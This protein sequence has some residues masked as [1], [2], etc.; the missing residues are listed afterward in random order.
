MKR[1]FLFAT[2]AILIPQ[3][4]GVATATELPAYEVTG[5][6]ITSVQASVVGSAHAQEISPQPTLTLGGMP[7]S[8]H[9]VAVLT[10]RKHIVGEL[11]T[12]P[13]TEGRAR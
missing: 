2:V 9:Q 4:A 13:V 3:G 11:P 12:K 8:P 1:L 6:P 7:A 5:F 10:L